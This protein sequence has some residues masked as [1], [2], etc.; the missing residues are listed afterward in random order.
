[1]IVKPTVPELLEKIGDNR[2]SLVIM[3]AKRARQIAT[4][5][6]V[7]V[8]SKERSVVTLAAEEIAEGNVVETYCGHEE[9]D[10][11]KEIESNEVK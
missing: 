6:P 11:V 2:Y 5:S 9:N 8:K 3:T 4:G 10:D 7:K 1:M